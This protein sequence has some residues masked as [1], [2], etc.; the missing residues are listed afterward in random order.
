MKKTRKR[1][2]ILSFVL[3]G[4]VLLLTGVLIARSVRALSADLA[5]ERE[6]N[7]AL[8]SENEQLLGETEALREEN[9]RLTGEKKDL[10]G[11]LADAESALQAA[12]EEASPEDPAEA[13]EAAGKEEK[14]VLPDEVY[15]FGRDGEVPSAEIAGQEDA[16]FSAFEIVEGDAVY[17][18]IAGKSYRP[19][20]DI[21]LRDL[22]Y[23]RIPH[24]D[25]DHK[26]RLGEMIVNRDAAVDTLAVFRDLYEA[27]YEIESMRLIDDFWAGD[28]DSSD[29]ASIRANN[30]SAFCYRTITDGSALS[31]H[32]L[33]RAIDLNPAQ[34]P[35]VRISG[36]AP[37]GVAEEDLPYVDRQ[38]GL[39]HM[40][41]K[42]DVCEAAFEEHGFSWGGDWTGPIDYQH[43]EKTS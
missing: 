39:P 34:N 21:A 33:G 29:W 17:E 42:G 22:M 43:F 7:A 24:Y 25:Y 8:A 20:P 19:N 36:G 3:L 30:T 13:E 6:K 37:Y 4:A 40:I 18:R 26:V 2:L 11:K 32:A 10:E 38:S 27:E 35:Y 23:L 14:T 12:D 1:L 41:L 9:K 31:N 28:G 15:A 16:W 5:S